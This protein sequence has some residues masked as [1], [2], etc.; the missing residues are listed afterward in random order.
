MGVEKEVEVVAT[1]HRF[2]LR[3]FTEA[4]LVDKEVHVLHAGETSV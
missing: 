2:F 3:Q 4:V 1:N